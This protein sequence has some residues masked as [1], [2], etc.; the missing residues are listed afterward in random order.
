MQTFADMT[1]KMSNKWFLGVNGKYQFTEDIEIKRRGDVKADN[2]RAGAHI[3][4]TL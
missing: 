3:G 1:Y 2:W 4:M